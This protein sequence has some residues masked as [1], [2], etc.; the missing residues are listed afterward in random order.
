[1]TLIFCFERCICLINFNPWGH[2]RIHCDSFSLGEKS[3]GAYVSSSY[4]ACRWFHVSL[5][6]SRIWDKRN[7]TPDI[8]ISLFCMKCGIQRGKTSRVPYDFS[9]DDAQE[10]FNKEDWKIFLSGLT[11]LLLIP[12]E[13]IWIYMKNKLENCA[14]QSVIYYCFVITVKGLLSRVGVKKTRL[15]MHECF[16]C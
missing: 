15:I 12:S 16:F 8:N 5:Y 3:A 10:N 7:D 2:I 1:M 11:W 9:G 13:I 14:Q 6:L 4:H